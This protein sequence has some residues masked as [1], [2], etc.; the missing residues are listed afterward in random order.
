LQVLVSM[1]LGFVIVFAAAV[2]AA[3]QTW[4]EYRPEK[5]GFRIEMPGAP[6]TNIVPIPVGGDETVPMTEAVVEA[7]KFSYLVSWVEYPDR[8]S[9]AFPAE[10]V[11][12]RVRD[13]MA[14]DGM[15]RGEKTLAGGNSAGREFLVIQ[16]NSNAA[17]RIWW[18]VSRLYQLTVT[19]GPGIEAQPDTRRFLDSFNLVAP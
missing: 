17:V 15:L 13:G 5:G 11:L 16:A 7:G 3:A 6:R 2:D 10:Q 12:D 9:R 19:G 14:A 18:S 1:C 8:L 4:N